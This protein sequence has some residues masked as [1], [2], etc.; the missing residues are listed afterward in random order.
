MRRPAIQAGRLS[1]AT[2]SAASVNSTADTWAKYQAEPPIE[3]YQNTVPNANTPVRPN[4]SRI[5]SPRFRRP[6]SR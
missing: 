1:S 2:M 6:S 5:R 3:T 4:R